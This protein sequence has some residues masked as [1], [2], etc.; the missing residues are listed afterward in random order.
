MVFHRF[1]LYDL[2]KG[3]PRVV[4]CAS[5]TVCVFYIIKSLDKTRKDPET[6]T[7]MQERSLTCKGPSLDLLVFLSDV[8]SHTCLALQ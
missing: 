2:T 7:K 5:G 3:Q 4:V 8:I 6:R 1:I